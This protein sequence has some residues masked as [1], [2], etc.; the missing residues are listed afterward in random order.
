MYSSSRHPI[1]S[2]QGYLIKMH[3]LEYGF[4]FNVTMIMTFYT[5]AMQPNLILDLPDVEVYRTSYRDG[6]TT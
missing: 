3:R 6:D 1:I 2:D 4:N 5:G